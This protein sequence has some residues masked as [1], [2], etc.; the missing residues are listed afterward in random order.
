MDRDSRRGYLE[1]DLPVAPFASPL[2]LLSASVRLWATRLGFLTGVTLLVYLPGHLL[3]QFAA[4]LFDLP[5]GGLPS[6][7]MVEVLDLI[8]AALVMPAAVYGLVRKTGGASLGDALRWGLRQWMRTL[9]NQVKVE[10]TVMLYGLLLIVPGVVAMVRLTFVPIIIAIEA[11]RQ[12]QPLEHSRSLA[13]G[14]F[15]RIF[16]VLLPIAIIDLAGNFLL[17]D[18]IP[19]VDDARIFFAIAESVLAVVGQLGTVAAL[20][21]YLGIAEPAQKMPGSKKPGQKKTA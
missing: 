6:L 5:S 2:R 12:A 21:M 18:R 16:A 19:K 10:I 13:D 15:W 17:L 3:F 14:Q 8:L 20:L 7:F 4:Y 9:G 1:S 11:D